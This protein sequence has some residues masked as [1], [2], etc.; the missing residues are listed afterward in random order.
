M[1]RRMKIRENW[2]DTKYLIIYTFM[3]S[4]LEKS[5]PAIRNTFTYCAVHINK[6]QWK[7]DNLI[8][9]TVWTFWRWGI[10]SYILIRWARKQDSVNHATTR[11]HDH[12]RKQRG[13]MRCDRFVFLCVQLVVWIDLMKP[14]RVYQSVSKSFRTES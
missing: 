3:I 4:V 12:S 9:H 7:N 1:R 10:S 14:L 11:M 6:N 13:D 8:S 2:R 5:S